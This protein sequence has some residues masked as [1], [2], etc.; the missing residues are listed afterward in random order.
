MARDDSRSTS[1]VG[2]LIKELREQLGWSQEK[3]GAAEQ[4]MKPRA[5]LQRCIVGPK[6]GGKL[7]IDDVKPD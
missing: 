1:I 5:L 6:K 7:L 3:L 2:R 4:K